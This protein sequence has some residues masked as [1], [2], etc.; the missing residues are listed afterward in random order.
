MINN[1]KIFEFSVESR[2]YNEYSTPRWFS[3]KVEEFKNKVKPYVFKDYKKFMMMNQLK[4]LQMVIREPMRH[5]I[6]CV[7]NL[8]LVEKVIF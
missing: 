5:Y 1:D 3:N 7:L 2:I 4:I 8:N 6:L